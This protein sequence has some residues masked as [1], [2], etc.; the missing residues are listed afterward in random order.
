M[1]E[2][3]EQKQQ[4]FVIFLLPQEFLKRLAVFCLSSMRPACS[5]SFLSLAIVHRTYKKD[6]IIPSCSG[7]GP[8]ARIVICHPVCSMSDAPIVFRVWGSFIIELVIKVSGL[9]SHIFSIHSRLVSN[10]SSCLFAGRGRGT[11]NAT[12]L[13]I[14]FALGLHL[15]RLSRIFF[16]HELYYDLKSTLW[17]LLV[18]VFRSPFC[19]VS[20]PSLLDK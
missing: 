19:L 11:F 14:F 17:R 2:S 1:K 7:E 13:S 18:W 10:V 5:M 15:G 9:P 8:P 12:I 4:R 20:R 16:F 3:F 6:M